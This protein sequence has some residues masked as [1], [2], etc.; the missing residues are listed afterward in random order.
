[1]NMEADPDHVT[2]L[3][4]DVGY[5]QAMLHFHRGMQVRP[6][7]L[8]GEPAKYPGLTT[9]PRAEAHTSSGQRQQ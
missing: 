6:R 9:P 2:E 4:S 8:R 5:N 7:C 1:M 3:E